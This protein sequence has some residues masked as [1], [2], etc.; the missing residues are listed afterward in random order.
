MEQILVVLSGTFITVCYYI[1]TPVK[2]FQFAMNFIERLGRNTAAM[3]DGKPRMARSYY[4]RNG[5]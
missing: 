3:P 1:V 4:V 5:K 2:L